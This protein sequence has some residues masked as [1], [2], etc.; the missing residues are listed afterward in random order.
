[1]TETAP[2]GSDV[3][4]GVDSEER[5]RGEKLRVVQLVVAC[6]Q[7]VVTMLAVTLHDQRLELESQRLVGIP[8][9]RDAMVSQPHRLGPCRVPGQLAG[10]VLQQQLEAFYGSDH[11]LRDHV[12]CDVHAVVHDPLADADLARK[13][14]VAGQE[15]HIVGFHGGS[16]VVVHTGD[17]PSPPGMR[18]PWW[19]MAHGCRR[20]DA[21]SSPVGRPRLGMREA[22]GGGVPLSGA[23]LKRLGAGVPRLVPVETTGPPWA[24]LAPM[25][26]RHEHWESSE[27]ITRECADYSPI[28]TTTGSRASAATPPISFE[29]RAKDT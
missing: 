12:L 5:L 24:V 18:I 1:M 22:L 21:A 13:A 17:T 20:R 28:G 4:V 8:A 6:H 9:G 29:S 11:V 2:S 10:H 16:P 15:R 14:V 26:L 23:P 3:P 27:L 19:V 25:S 7:Q